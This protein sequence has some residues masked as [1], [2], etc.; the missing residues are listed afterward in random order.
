MNNGRRCVGIHYY[1]G[2]REKK[3]KAENRTKASKSRDR[4][5]E[6]SRIERKKK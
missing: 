1:N 4:V 6:E 3:T 2:D 5:N